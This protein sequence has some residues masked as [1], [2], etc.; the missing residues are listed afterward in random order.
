MKK[1]H[2]YIG[3]SG[4]SYNHW[5]NDVFYPKSISSNKWLEFYCG[6]F[7]SVELNVTFY[8]LP[9]IKAY[10]TWQKQTPRNFRFVLKGSRFI[11]H[12]KRLKNC[13]QPLK[14]FFN[15]AVSLREK[16][17]CVLWQLPPNFKKDPGRLLDF[18]RQLKKLKKIRQAFEFRNASWF[19]T[20]IFKILKDNNIALAS[21]DWPDF[22]KTVHD[23]AD[24]VYIRRH[25]TGANLYGGCYTQA[26]L[27]R[28]ALFIKS[29]LK[30]GK[31][32]YMYFNNDARGYAPQNALFLKKLLI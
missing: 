9:S 10:K 6:K 13:S 3:T 29:F 16:T 23:T 32:V 25:G 5:K 24:F 8:R 2:H 1:A 27:K 31:D 28:D 4:Y 7:D 19:S 20:E 21:A 14:V 15:R 12:I 11:T 17:S 30:K 26:Q 22:S 18:I